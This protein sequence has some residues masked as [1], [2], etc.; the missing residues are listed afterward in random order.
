MWKTQANREGISTAPSDPWK[1]VATS[2]SV[3]FVKGAAMSFCMSLP[4]QKLGVVAASS[5]AA[6][7]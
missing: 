6:P 1:M 7:A 4:L 5:P 2:S 3:L